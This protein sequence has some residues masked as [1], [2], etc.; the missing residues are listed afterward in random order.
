MDPV[1]GTFTTMDTYGGSLS[2][3]MSLHKY[4]FA[5]SNP[6]MY[7][8]PSG[9]FSLAEMDLS[10]AI[11]RILDSAIMSGIFYCVDANATDPEHE[12]HDIFGYFGAIGLGIIFGAVVIMLSSTLVGLLILAIINTIL[13]V[14]GTIK[15]VLDILNGHPVYGGLEIISSTLLIWFGWRNYTSARNAGKS[16]GLIHLEAKRKATGEGN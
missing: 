9:H 7:S 4:L 15:G 1:T 11:D 8:D 10:M 13:G 16:S 12:H 6:V 2:D 3:P 5:N 14:V